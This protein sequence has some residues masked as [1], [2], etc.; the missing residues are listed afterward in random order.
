[1]NNLTPSPNGAENR[2]SK[3]MFNAGIE[4]KEEM[5]GEGRGGEK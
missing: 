3:M 2:V 4:D 5:G 1:M